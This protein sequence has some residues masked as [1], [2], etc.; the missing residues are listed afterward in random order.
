MGRKHLRDVVH[1]H[2]QSGELDEFE[3]DALVHCV[4]HRL[5]ADSCGA[6]TRDEFVK[7][8]SA[9]ETMELADIAKFFDIHRKKSIL[10]RL[11]DATPHEVKEHKVNALKRS[12]SRGWQSE[13]VIE[14][15]SISDRRTGNASAERA[16]SGQSPMASVDDPAKGESKDRT[17]QN[18]W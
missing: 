11:F 18:T 8:C 2:I 3:F 17:I 6:I 15:E 13:T 5:D 9:K 4:M 12:D 7:A 14:T 1:N 16:V 10:E